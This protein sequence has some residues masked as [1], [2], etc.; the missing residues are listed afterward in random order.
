MWSVSDASSYRTYKSMFMPSFFQ[1]ATTGRPWVTS[2]Q[3]SIHRTRLR[4]GTVFRW[5]RLANNAATVCCEI[6]H[7]QLDIFVIVESWHEQSGGLL[8]DCMILCHQLDVCEVT[9][10]QFDW[11]YQ[12]LHINGQQWTDAAHRRYEHHNRW[13]CRFNVDILKFG[14]HDTL[15]TLYARMLQGDQ[16]A[17]A[18]DRRHLQSN[19]SMHH[20]ECIALYR[21]QFPKMSILR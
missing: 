12:P 15:Q 1:R 4:E 14:V 2:Q 9:M 16:Q 5:H 6:V 20:Y 21:H 17:P 7:E 13:H 19:N 3:Y 11:L 10:C 8:A 18:V